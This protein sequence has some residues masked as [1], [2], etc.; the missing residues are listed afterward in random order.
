MTP[1]FIIAVD[2][3]LSSEGGYVHH[4]QDPGMETKYGISKRTYKDVDIKN[5][6]RE[7]AKE[8]YFR[9]FWTPVCTY[10]S[11]AVRYQVFDAAVNHGM[12]NA[13]R[14]LQRAVRVADDGHWGAISRGAY[15]KTEQ[16]D[17]LLRF[18]AE[19]LDFMRKLSTFQV[20]GA[21]WSARI[22]KNLR[23]ASEDA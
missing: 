11:P 14:M 15:S 17:V 5:L 13:V 9:D 22:V 21:G 4:V 18:L 7:Q 20:F 10:L 23:Y 12:G 1:E 16:H 6:T 19:R 3:T 8:I 2:R